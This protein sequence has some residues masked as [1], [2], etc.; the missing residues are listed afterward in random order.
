MEK[1]ESLSLKASFYDILI[2]KTS[3]YISKLQKKCRN[4]FKEIGLTENIAD[5]VFESLYEES[6][7]V[8]ILSEGMDGTFQD[9]YIVTDFGKR[10]ITTFLEVYH[11]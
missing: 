4:H 3:D 6:K 5:L 11:L 8:G 7:F 2:N 9:R 1:E 10:Q